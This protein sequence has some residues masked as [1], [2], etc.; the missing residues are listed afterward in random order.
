MIMYSII[1]NEI[2]FKDIKENEESGYIEIDYLGEKVQVIESTN[3][4]YVIN[5]IISTS[6]KAFINPNLQPGTIIEGNIKNYL[7]FGKVK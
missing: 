3:N 6:L 2:I 1:P 4:K 7:T 5:R